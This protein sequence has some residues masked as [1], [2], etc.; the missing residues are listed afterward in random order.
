MNKTN[1][2]CL[3]CHSDKLYKF[4]LKNQAK[5][6]ADKFKTSLNLQYDDWNADETVVFINGER[7]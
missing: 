2:K 7:H 1:I 6:K 4:C 5:Q 3:R